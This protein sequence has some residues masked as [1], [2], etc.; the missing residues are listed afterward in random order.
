ML[1][2]RQREGSGEGLLDKAYDREP[3]RRSRELRN[4]AT[5]AERRLCQHLRSRQLTGVRFNRQV[6]IGPYICDLVARTPKLIIELD[7]GQHAD[8]ADYDAN[9]TTFLQQRG[10]R[11][12][13]FW[14]NDVLEN[15]EGVL[16]V[17]EE[18]L[19]DRPSP[20]PSRTAGGE[21]R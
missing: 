5:Q 10:Y 18:A 17:I 16:T 15:L 20:G 13:R 21:Q 12:I 8:A 2:S 1:P 4:N 9:R 3:T 7:G 6:P 11:V 14:N 19:K